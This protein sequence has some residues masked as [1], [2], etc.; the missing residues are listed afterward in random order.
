MQQY[1]VGLELTKE[2]DFSLHPGQVISDK[3]RRD[4]E[5]LSGLRGNINPPESFQQFSPF[6]FVA[7]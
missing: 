3:T 2:A 5:Q 7:M 6:V 1:V 4:S